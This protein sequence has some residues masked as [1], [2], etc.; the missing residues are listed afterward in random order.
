M[1]GAD[2]RGSVVRVCPVCKGRPD[3]GLY[4][5]FNCR[6]SPHAP[7]HPGAGYV[8][9]GQSPAEFEPGQVLVDVY[10]GDVWDLVEVRRGRRVM[11]RRDDG[12]EHDVVF[13]TD[14]YITPE[15]AADPATWEKPAPSA[16]AAEPAG[17]VAARAG[18]GSGSRQGV[19][20]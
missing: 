6:P 9:V 17:E 13:C 14:R 5:C 10:R 2:V 12:L 18:A 15:R 11:R 1:S 20:L 19:L 16:L 8:L 3:A 4:A 7:N